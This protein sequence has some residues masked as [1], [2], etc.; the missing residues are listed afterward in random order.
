VELASAQCFDSLCYGLLIWDLQGL[1]FKQE[2]SVEEMSQ[3]FSFIL[4][5]QEE[6]FFCA[7]IYMKNLSVDQEFSF[8]L[9]PW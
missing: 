4:L 5:A 3:S 6:I 8:Q 7:Y 1:R 2:E 9:C